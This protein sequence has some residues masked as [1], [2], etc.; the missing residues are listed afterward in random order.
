[1]SPN[2]C[3]LLL[4]AALLAAC[5]KPGET[6][7]PENPIADIDPAVTTA[8]HDQILID[9]AL[10]QQSN[11]NA[12]RPSETPLQALYPIDL[13]PSAERE[14]D[15]SDGPFDRDPAWARRLPIDFALPAGVR[16]VEAAANNARGCSVR[17]VTFRSGDAPGPMLDLYRARAAAAGYSVRHGR[18]DGDHILAGSNS[19]GATYHLIVTPK[20][21]GS[22]V[23]L[24]TAG[25]V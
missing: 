21:A 3:L 17:V 4:S 13:D 23:A 25:G 18:R 5:G 24:V 20:A 14:A 12:L 22:E 8:L 9:P 16:S 7:T 15:C 6:A 1:M 19:T 2:T 10:S 11:I